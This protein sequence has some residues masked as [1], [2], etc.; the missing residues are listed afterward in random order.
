MYTVLIESTKSK[1]FKFIAFKTEKAAISFCIKLKQK[2]NTLTTKII[3]HETE[4]M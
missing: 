1:G 4:T 3:T 2:C